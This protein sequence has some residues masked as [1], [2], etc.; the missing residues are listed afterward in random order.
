MKK[1][2]DIQLSFLRKNLRPL[3]IKRLSIAVAALSLAACSQKK[4]EVLFV[5][6]AEECANKTQLSIEECTA[7]YKKALAESEKTGP[8][9]ASRGQC[10]VDFGDN[11]CQR[12]SGGYFMPFMAGF[13]VSQL[14]TSAMHSGGYYGTYNPGY[15]YRNNYS[16]DRNKIMTADGNIIGRPGKSRYNVKPS[17]LKPKPKTLTTVKRGGFG[18]KAAAKSNWGGG[19]SHKSWGG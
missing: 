5:Q 2:K 11:Q 17:A 3:R 14:M 13:M 4:E 18:A 10:E 12:S 19:K 6:S 1:S 15:L 9:Y 16:Y 7:A 8:K